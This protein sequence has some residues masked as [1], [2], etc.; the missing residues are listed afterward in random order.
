[1]NQRE[2]ALYFF[3]KLVY[4]IYLEIASL[5]AEIHPKIA[6]KADITNGFFHGE[7]Q[8]QAAS[9]YYQVEAEVDP[10]KILAPF[11]ERTGL[12]LEDTYQAFTEGSWQNKFGK[13]NF[14]GPKW[15]RINEAALRLRDLIETQAWEDA[16]FLIFD[17]KRMKTNQG[18]LVN[19]FE[20]SERRRNHQ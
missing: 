17:I 14:G 19:Q 18:S 3:R 1:M 5:T 11:I 6:A 13:H 12:T 4:V 16:S 2:E 20:W 8:K 10:G 15:A 7:K 9:L